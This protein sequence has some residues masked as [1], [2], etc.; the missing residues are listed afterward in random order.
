MEP[1][2]DMKLSANV[3]ALLQ[4]PKDNDQARINTDGNGFLFCTT[5]DYRS[6][7]VS[8]TSFEDTAQIITATCH[9][10]MKE[11]PQNTERAKEVLNRVKEIHKVYSNRLKGD[12][13]GIAALKATIDLFDKTLQEKG[14]NFTSSLCGSF[15]FVDEHPVEVTSSDS[16]WRGVACQF[17]GNFYTKA[18]NLYT[19][20]SQYTFG[21]LYPHEY[22]PST[23]PIVLAR[24]QRIANIGCQLKGSDGDEYI[25]GLYKQVPFNSIHSLLI[26]STVN[27]LSLNMLKEKIDREGRAFVNKDLP[28]IIP[29]GFEYGGMLE[30]NHVALIVIKDNCVE[31]Y[32]SKG[33]PCPDAFREVLEYCMS[34]FT[35]GGKIAE[36]RRVD[37][38]D[39]HNC[40]VYICYHITDRLV[41][42]SPMGVFQSPGPT[43]KDIE[44]FRKEILKVACPPDMQVEKEDERSADLMA[45]SFSDFPDQDG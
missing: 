16:S 28:I 9:G 4:F 45:F 31:Y 13:G 33:L 26:G 1:I 34:S 10:L 5:G 37:Q 25:K 12:S 36:N 2:E 8:G 20:A 24:Q 22:T 41:K 14:G 40:V 42:N 6:V 23:D 30:R 39:I 15:V 18:N 43:L 38:S 11:M 19:T 7:A 21:T 44:E 29:I 32:D 35:K 27:T 3:E 17:V